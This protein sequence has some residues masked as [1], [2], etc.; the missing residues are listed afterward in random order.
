MSLKQQ[1]FGDESGK[2]VGSSLRR[3]L[4]AELKG[5]NLSNLEFTKNFPM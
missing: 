5:M 1:A 3:A 4:S 2:E